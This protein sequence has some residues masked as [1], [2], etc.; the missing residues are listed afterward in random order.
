MTVVDPRWVRPVP[1]ELVG[2]AA[3][4]RLVVTVED[5]VRT[6]GV[7]DAVA[8]ALRDADVGCRCATSAC[9]GAGTRTAAARRS[10]PTWASPPRTWPAT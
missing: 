1:V 7:G 6:G 3:G 8:K 2:L 9:R 10:S 5:G 4:H